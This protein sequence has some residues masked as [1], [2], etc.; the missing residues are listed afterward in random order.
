[1][2]GG[3]DVV[4]GLLE[5]GAGCTDEGTDGVDDADDGPVPRRTRPSAARAR[6]GAPADSSR[7]HESPLALATISATTSD[8]AVRV[9]LDVL[10]TPGRSTDHDRPELFVVPGH[11]PIVRRAR[12][13]G[14]PRR[15]R[16]VGYP[17][18]N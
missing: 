10:P 6:G 15:A 5:G 4:G 17:A 16:T 7:P 14:P 18:R 8:F 2:L 9:V 1:M 11:G 13:E 12:T 3:A